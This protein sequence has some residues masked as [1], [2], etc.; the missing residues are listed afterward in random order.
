M[1]AVFLL[2]RNAALDLRCI[3]ARSRREWGEG[4][5]D[6]YLADLY[7]AMG[8]A[9]ANPEKGRLR[10]RRS[11]PFLMVPARQH[12]VIYDLVPQGIAVLAVQHQVRDVEALITE[13][14][15]SFHAEHERLKRKA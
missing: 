7:A 3:H 15:P 9:A 8:D 13:L 5:A 4:V 6:R 2:T 11:A 12:F 14:T 10:K 1:P